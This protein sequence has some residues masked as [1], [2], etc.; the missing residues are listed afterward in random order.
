[1]LNGDFGVQNYP[2]QMGK[3]HTKNDGPDYRATTWHTV[4]HFATNGTDLAVS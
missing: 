2:Q 1:M 4:V 3:F